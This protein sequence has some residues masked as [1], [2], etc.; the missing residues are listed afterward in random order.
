MP[1]LVVSGIFAADPDL[2]RHNVAHDLKRSVLPAGPV[3]P[4]QRSI[5]SHEGFIQMLC[6]SEILFDRLRGGILNREEVV[7]ARGEE[8]RTKNYY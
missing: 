1:E 3:C 2:V 6:R 8:N 4:M 5:G 7:A